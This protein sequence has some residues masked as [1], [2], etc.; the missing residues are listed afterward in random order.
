MWGQEFNDLNFED[1]YGF[2][3]DF[4]YFCS[5]VS[6]VRYRLV[7]FLLKQNIIKK[8]SLLRLLHK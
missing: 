8:A 4:V 2:G 1:N 3:I 7:D 5:F 6:S